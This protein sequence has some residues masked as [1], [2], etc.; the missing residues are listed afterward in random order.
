MGAL[1]RQRTTFS[2]DVFSS[3]Y[4]EELALQIN[5]PNTELD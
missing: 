3:T 1:E 5:K 4:Q 2:I